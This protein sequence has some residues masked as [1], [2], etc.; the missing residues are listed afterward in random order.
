MSASDLGGHQVHVI[1]EG[2][3]KQEIGFTYAGF[4]LDVHVDPVTLNEFD[5]FQ[6]RSAPEPAGFLVYDGDLVPSLE[7]RCYCS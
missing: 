7:K 1:I 3:R 6:L 4:A 2:H 5:A